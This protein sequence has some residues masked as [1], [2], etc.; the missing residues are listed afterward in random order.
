MPERKPSRPSLPLIALVL[1]AVFALLYR[2]G[3]TG[4]D[5]SAASGRLTVATADGQVQGMVSSTASGA[6]DEFLGIPYAAPP[7]GRLRWQP[8]QPPAPWH[9]VRQATRFAPH[10]P[11]P[12]S[13]FGAASTSENC[14]YLNVFAPAD[15]GD[16]KLPV[17][18]WLYGGS[19]LVGE[20]DDY[21]PAALVSHGVIV[22]T[23]N[24]RIG[25]LGFLADSALAGRPGGPAGNYGLM[26][27]QAALRWV[28]RNI[29]GFGGD[30]HDV[31]LFG[32][33]A[34]GLSVLAQLTSPGARG[35]FS[36]ALI[37]SGTY[38]LTQEPLATAETAGAAFAAKVGCTRDVAACLRGL[39]VKAIV[40]NEDFSGYRPDVD[41]QVL[42]EPVSAALRSGDFSRVPVVIG[43]NH[44]EW[45][46][47]V[48]MDSLKGAPVTA[49][50]YQPM[51]AETLGVPAFA[52]AAI[53][54]EYPLTAYPSPSVALGAVG[55]DAIFACPALS[56]EESL[57]RYV[58]VY[59]YEFNDENAPERYLPP[60]GFAYGAAHESE[61]QYLF[62][63][64]NTPFPGVLSGGQR[65]LA[66]AMQADWTNF[67]KTGQPAPAA[68]WPRF[69]PAEPGT[70]SLVPP[71]PRIETDYATE[72]HCGFW[73]AVSGGA[74]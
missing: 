35:L 6:M 71:Q 30:R 40:D 34:G 12:P 13:A 67:A 11:Q 65:A 56:A 16:R 57:S 26:D 9:G 59:A 39:P 1:V 74:S 73:A 15:R 29:G 50:D 25:A 10:C 31:T 70:L 72:H 62:T 27:Q 32:E 23:L 24:Y 21:G 36:A 41:G 46:L 37:E 28:Q 2:G 20:S 58:P 14:L 63:L 5:A 64:A 60:A 8:P 68:S 43:T 49:A 55:T 18:V 69:T 4:S 66:A 52:A 3:G 44:D 7:V 61:V 54:G 17:M 38:A 45:R 19:L 22:V 48:A 47:F 51:I 42:T 33:S 53:A